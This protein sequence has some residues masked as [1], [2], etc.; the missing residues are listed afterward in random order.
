VA[1]P[2]LEGSIPSPRRGLRHA[3]ERRY[4]RFHASTLSRP[5]GPGTTS[6]WKVRFL[7]HDP[8]V[9]GEVAAGNPVGVAGCADD[10]RANAPAAE[11]PLIG[12]RDRCGSGPRAGRRRHRLRHLGVTRDPGRLVSVGLTALRSTQMCLG[13]TRPT[14]RGDR[15]AS[16]QPRSRPIRLTRWRVRPAQLHRCPALETSSSR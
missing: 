8:Q 10:V 15:V 3:Q 13:S 7:D 12:V 6:A 2:R 9:M 4:R 14:E 16:R 1:T 11:L 5:A